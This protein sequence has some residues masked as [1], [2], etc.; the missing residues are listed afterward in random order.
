MGEDQKINQEAIWHR[1]TLETP[2]TVCSSAVVPSVPLHSLWDSH[3]SDH[4]NRGIYSCLIVTDG[5]RVKHEHSGEYH[6][7]CACCILSRG[8]YTLEVCRHFVTTLSTA[9]FLCQCVTKYTHSVQKHLPHGISF[10]CLLHLGTFCGR[11]VYK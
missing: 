7:A 1:G 9:L 3:T 2:T 6:P 10:V 8:A 11:K 4:N 5:S